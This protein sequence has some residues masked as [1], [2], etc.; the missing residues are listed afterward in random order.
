MPAD[1]ELNILILLKA[2]IID[3]KFATFVFFFASLREIYSFF[4]PISKYHL[5]LGDPRKAE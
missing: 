4:T 1:F 2:C 5:S 3:R